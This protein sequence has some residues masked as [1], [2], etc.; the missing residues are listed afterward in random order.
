[1]QMDNFTLQMKNIHYKV[2]ETIY[3][4]ADNANGGSNV[5]PPQDANPLALRETPCQLS[6]M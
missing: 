5:E 3:K 2:G 1:M 6:M 4:V